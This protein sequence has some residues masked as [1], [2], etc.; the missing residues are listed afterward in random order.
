MTKVYI[1]Y[2]TETRS[3]NRTS[4]N[5][6]HA[7]MHLGNEYDPD[8][9]D[10]YVSWWPDG[11]IGLRSPVTK[12]A[13]R[14]LTYDIISEGSEP[15]VIYTLDSVSNSDLAMNARWKEIKYKKGAHYKLYDKN[16]AAIVAQVLKAG[17]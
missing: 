15:H 12:A 13:P 4:K 6:G 3:G 5:I 2:P 10:Y 14:T 17:D 16:C 7:S 1:W 9:E 11:A 8:K